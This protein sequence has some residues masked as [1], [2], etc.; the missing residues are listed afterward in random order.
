MPTRP[1]PVSPPP[2]FRRVALRGQVRPAGGASFEHWVG[3]RSSVVASTNASDLPFQRWHRFKEA[4]DPELI[5]RA[6]RESPRPVQSLADPFGGSGTS[7]LAA[8]FLG[9]TPSTVEVNPFLADLIQAKVAT[10]HVPTLI[11][12][13]THVCDVTRRSRSQA[14]TMIAALPATFI[15]PGVKGRWLFDREVALEILRLRGAIA[16]LEDPGIARLFRV[17]LGGLMT[18]FSNATVSGKGRRY[19]VNWENRPVNPRV[20]LAAF[21]D[22]A[23]A[24]IGEIDIF[25]DRPVREATVLCGDSRAMF[26]TLKPV[27]LIVCSPPY[28]NSFDYTDVYNLELWMLGYLASAQDNRALRQSTLTSHVQISRDFAAAPLTP[29]LNRTMKALHRSAS[30]L[31][32][33]RLPAMVGGYFA[34]LLMLLHASA[35][36][37]SEGGQAWFVVGDSQYAQVHVQVARILKEL[38]PLAG[39]CVEY[40]TPFRSMRVSPQQSGRPGLSEDLVVMTR[41]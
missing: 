8:Q 6:V 20:V 16:Q 40:M 24:A 2:S 17:I 34:D 36:L 32:D 38:A 21:S 22:A 1:Q 25:A 10:Y 11:S 31:W 18:S 26:K 12:A 37:L 27:D 4:F 39:F 7:A 33:H 9:V 13:L 30:Q 15:E 29:T 5:A 41:R 35:R 14:G 23:A 3:S 19:R 28:P